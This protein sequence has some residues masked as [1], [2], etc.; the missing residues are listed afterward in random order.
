MLPRNDSERGC[1]LPIRGGTRGGG[2]AHIRFLKDEIRIKPRRRGI[3]VDRT[4]QY[5]AAQREVI[6]FCIAKSDSEV[7]GNGRDK[8]AQTGVE[9]DRRADANVQLL[10]H[11][12]P[13]VYICEWIGGGSISHT[14]PFIKPYRLVA[15]EKS[16]EESSG[17]GESDSSAGRTHASFESFLNDCLLYRDSPV[18]ASEGRKGKY[19]HTGIL[20]YWCKAIGDV[21]VQV[22][23]GIF[24]LN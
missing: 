1:R 20:N 6:K 8:M 10:R 9:G 4:I 21:D 13:I 22:G 15:S 24:A 16:T 18:Y 23:I 2:R 5:H 7:Q 12:W 17:V 14:N 11:I 3:P 19:P